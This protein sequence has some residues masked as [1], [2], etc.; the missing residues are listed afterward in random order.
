MFLKVV[1]DIPQAAQAHPDHS[2]QAQTAC[3][4]RP[5]PRSG[6]WHPIATPGTELQPGSATHW[7]LVGQHWPGQPVPQY[8]ASLPRARKPGGDP[9]AGPSHPCWL[10]WN[11]WGS[12]R[13]ALSAG[14][15][16]TVRCQRRGSR[17]KQRGRGGAAAVR[18]SV[19]NDRFL[20]RLPFGLASE[21][22]SAIRTKI[23][24][25]DSFCSTLWTK[26]RCC[27]P[28][29]DLRVAYLTTIPYTG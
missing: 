25:R 18:L 19:M 1:V 29:L 15:I 11:W 17:I 6:S 4:R 5:G 26:T 23:C 28:A 8:D 10:A 2:G 21:R 16:P 22:F 14:Q 12:G 13:K 9:G 24:F 20:G 27:H 7:G 3:D